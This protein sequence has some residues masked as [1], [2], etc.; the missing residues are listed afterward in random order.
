MCSSALC[1][2][3]GRGGEGGSKEGGSKEGGGGRNIIIVIPFLPLHLP[4]LGS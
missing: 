4:F 2:S 1:P 3:Q